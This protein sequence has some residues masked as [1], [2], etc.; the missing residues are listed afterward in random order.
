MRQSKPNYGF[1]GNPGALILSLLIISILDTYLF[2]LHD[3]AFRI[4][5]LSLLACNAML[6]AVTLWWILYVKIGKLRHR[7]A[8]LSIIGWNGSEKVLDIGT[9]R[10]LLMIGA[11]KKLNGGKCIGIDIWRKQDL[12]NNTSEQTLRNAKTEGVLDRI[13]IK[14]EDVRSLSFPTSFFD[15]IFSNLCLHNI[16]SKNERENA[17]REITRVLKPK[18]I[19][20]ISDRFHIKEYRDTFEKEGLSA[21]IVKAKFP[22]TSVWLPVVVAV[23]K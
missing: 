20:V 11:A 16:S 9:G 19:A 23:K 15:V 8:L 1:D 18:G 14:N 21:K 5:A 7:D 17:C 3:V 4:A 12:A 10:G 22:P 6:I 2:I 13:E